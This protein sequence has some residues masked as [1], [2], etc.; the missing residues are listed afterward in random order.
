MTLNR[1]DVFPFTGKR[2]E[3]TIDVNLPHFCK[4]RYRILHIASIH[5]VKHKDQH[6]NDSDNCR[7]LRPS[8]KNVTQKLKSINGTQ[9][10]IKFAFIP[11]FGV[12]GIANNCFI[13]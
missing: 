4:Q 13:G 12:V 5:V 7:C 11:L 1:W 8:N 10:P 6:D 2:K 9:L 3:I